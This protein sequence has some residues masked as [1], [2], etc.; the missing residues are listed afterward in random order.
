MQA[1]SSKQAKARTFVTTLVIV[2]GAY[3]G[4]RHMSKFPTPGETGAPAEESH[5]LSQRA[6]AERLESRVYWLCDDIGR[7]TSRFSVRKAQYQEGLEFALQENGFV[8]ESQEYTV[9]SSRHQNT[10]GVRK[11]SG[12]GTILIGTHHDSYGK[13]PCANASGTGV[14]TV[15]ELA[16]R[17]RDESFGPTVILAFFGTGEEPNVG[18]STMGAQVWLDAQ[19]EEGGHEIDAAYLVGSFGCFRVGEVGQNSEF[20]WYLSHPESA[21]WVG[22]YGGFMGRSAVEDTL[23]AWSRVT[24]LPARGFAAPH[25]FLGIPESDQIP[26]QKAGI[27]SVLFSDTGSNRDVSLYTTFDLPSAINYTEM[28]RRV[29]ALAMMLMD[30]INGSNEQALADAR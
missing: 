2:A 21:D 12:E 24:D 16:D 14:A 10:I 29:D 28:A 8:L 30:V 6:L 7:R 19:E 25:W 22:V 9:G 17:F 18:R 4:F 15:M 5:E 13:S 26:F 20:P 27:P 3:A 23:A 11:G 1:R